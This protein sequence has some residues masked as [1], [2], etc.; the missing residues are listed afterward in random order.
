[1][2]SDLIEKALI[3]IDARKPKK[4]PDPIGDIGILKKVP[5]KT[6]SYTQ[7]HR[8]QWFK[9]EYNLQEI[10]V[11][12]ASDSFLARAIKKKTDRFMIAGY[13]FYGLDPDSVGYVIK[14]AAEIELATNLPF[15]ILLQQTVQDMFRYSNA[16]WVKVRNEDASSGQLR[17]DLSGTE[18][19]PVAGYFLLPFETLQFKTK[20]NGEIKKVLQVMESD[21]KEYAP[22]DVIHFYS[23][24][25]PGFAIGTPE[26]LPALDDIALLRRMEENVEELVETNLFPTFHYT[27]GTDLMPERVSPTGEKESDIIKKKLEYMPSGGIYISDHRHTI[28]VLGAESK[29]LRIDFYLTYFKNRVLGGLGISS[30]DVGEGDT[31]NRS[32]AATMSKSLIQDVEAMQNLMKTFIEFYV[33]NELLLEG[34]Y[35]PLDENEKVEIKFG[36]IDR[37]EQNSVENQAIQIWHA[38]GITHPEFRK[39]L[40]HRAFKDEDYD[41]TYF[42]KFEEPL[43]LVQHMAPGSAASTTLGGLPHSN[44]EPAAVNAEKAFTIKQARVAAAKKPGGQRTRSGSTGSKRASAAKARPSNQHGTRSAPKY[45][46]DLETQFA[47][48]RL[49]STAFSIAYQQDLDV[50]N[51]LLEERIQAT[52]CDPEVVYDNLAYRFDLLTQKYLDACAVQ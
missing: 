14:R 15:R 8:G 27:I 39:R 52:N 38:Q 47:I 30:I 26:V 35:N 51:G 29:A 1:M 16:M 11:A 24:R 13:E 18:V 41:D 20:P 45:S 43:A 33:V 48:E 22:Q 21:Q 19:K 10:Q 37:E 44:V 5:D 3:L 4:T 40:G 25:N 32:T 28:D 9:P 17:V 36:V 23:N 12:Q 34:G 46:K 49:G 31:S 6:L 2:N 7:R 50:L 42:K